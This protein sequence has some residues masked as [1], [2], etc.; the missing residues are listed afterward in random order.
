[1]S[2]FK[3]EKKNLLKLSLFSSVSSGGATGWEEVS[4]LIFKS[5]CSIIVDVGLSVNRVS[6]SR[7]IFDRVLM[8]GSYESCTYASYL[9]CQHTFL[10]LIHL[11]SLAYKTKI[12]ST[13][14]TCSMSAWV[15]PASFL[16]TMNM[17]IREQV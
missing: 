13:C 14:Y 15:S 3:I 5:L 4:P 16:S 1:M 12:G 7:D 9:R 10:C 17:E 2:H 6:R 8:T 11:C